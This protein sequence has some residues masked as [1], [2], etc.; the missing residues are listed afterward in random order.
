MGELKPPIDGF[1]KNSLFYFLNEQKLCKSSRK[2]INVGLLSGVEDI[3][4]EDDDEEISLRSRTSKNLI[5]KEKLDLDLQDEEL[6]S[7]IHQAQLSL[8][9]NFPG[10]SIDDDPFGDENQVLAAPLKSSGCKKKKKGKSNGVKFEYCIGK[11]H[12]LPQIIV[13]KKIRLSFPVE[14]H[15]FDLLLKNNF[16]F[17]DIDVFSL[18][19][20]SEKC[21]ISKRIKKMMAPEAKEIKFELN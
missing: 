7:T 4:S 12:K 15:L 11:L 8:N 1:S 20:N 9:Q 3:S 5:K 18:E 16:I 10:K 2:R 19:L 21:E 13:N 14:N 17:R 6:P